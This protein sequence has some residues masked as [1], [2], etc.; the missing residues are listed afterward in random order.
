MPLLRPR[1]ATQQNN[2]SL[3]GSQPQTSTFLPC[4]PVHTGK[5]AGTNR[6][7][8]Y[9]FPAWIHRNYPQ[10]RTPVF[11]S[12]CAHSA[13]DPKKSRAPRKEKAAHSARPRAPGPGS[14]HLRAT[15]HLG[16][17]GAAS[18]G[19][20]PR[21]APLLAA[22]PRGRAAVARRGGSQ[23]GPARPPFFPRTPGGKL[24]GRRPSAS[25][26]CPAPGSAPTWPR[27]GAAG[28]DTATAPD[29]SDTHPLARELGAGRLEAAGRPLAEALLEKEAAARS[30]GT[31]RVGR[32]T[33]GIS[34]RRGAGRRR[35]ALWGL[36]SAST[37]GPTAG[38]GGSG[39]RT[40]APRERVLR[41]G[42]AGMSAARP[43]FRAAQSKPAELVPIECSI[44][45]SCV[46]PAAA[47]RVRPAPCERG[48]L[49][50]GR[51]TG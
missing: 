38:G 44:R 28:A 35:A 4:T 26:R 11:H 13:D 15:P 22:G 36:E 25:G 49:R 12:R 51:H 23:R 46:A 48:P 29:G 19:P 41:S 30:S 10:G 39:R 20:A 32:A 5:Q 43:R 37:S 2:Y 3:P 47:A 27:R 50:G 33:C 18:P 31:G 14:G 17:P 9:Y 40:T 1:G 8:R 21:S 45:G 16:H 42:S 34:H 24:L 6:A 7:R